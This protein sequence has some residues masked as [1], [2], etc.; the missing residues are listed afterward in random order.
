MAEKIASLRKKTIIPWLILTK[1][2]A[3]NLNSGDAELKGIS[4]QAF[5]SL[6]LL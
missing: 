5:T 3:E 2:I 1:S 6:M 4:F